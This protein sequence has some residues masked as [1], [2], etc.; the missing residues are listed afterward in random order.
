MKSI[1]LDSPVLE[2]RAAERVRLLLREKP[3]AILALALG[4]DTVALYEHLACLCRQGALSFREA[5]IFLAGDFAGAAPEKSRRRLLTEKL[6]A[7]IDV[8]QENCFFPPEEIEDYDRRIARQGGLDL[9]VLD[10]GVNARIA[11]NEPATPFDSLSR[12]QK[13]SPA[14]RRELAAELGGEEQVPDYAVTLGIGS[15]MAA[16]ELM[17]LAKGEDKAEAAFQMLYAR[18]DSA[19][20]AAF[21]TL[22]REASAF[23]DL[24]A[25]AKL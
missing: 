6:L 15:L 14:T 18:S 8:R 11:F 10:L 16:R 7:H 4:R 17:V 13:L 21:L 19:V 2:E 25:A 22:A 12:R 23:L 5:R 3:R 1:V 20:P 24:A 9:A